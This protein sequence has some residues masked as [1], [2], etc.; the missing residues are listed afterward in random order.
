MSIAAE[1]VRARLAIHAR[2]AEPCFYSDAGT[3]TTPSAEQLA[4]GLTL[5]VRF[6]T[7]TKMFSPE[8]DGLSIMENVE[9]LI[10]IQPQLDAL[11]I[12]L[13]HAGV[14]EIPGFGIT[15]QLDQPLDPDGP[16][17]VYWTVVRDV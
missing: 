14:V 17:Q 9:R 6:A 13:D 2:M 12:T 5:T 3:P 8:G 7:K 4:D 11:G 10:F 15:L 16:L 1:K